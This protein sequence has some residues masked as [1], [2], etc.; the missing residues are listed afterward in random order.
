[1]SKGT[2]TESPWITTARRKPE[3]VKTLGSTDKMWQ[4][5]D[6]V[7]GYYPHNMHHHDDVR[8]LNKRILRFEKTYNPYS[9]K[10][11]CPVSREHVM[12]P[13][14]WMEIPVIWDK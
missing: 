1:M 14:K 4:H 12:P 6:I 8:F 5:S 9:T 3:M 7:I 10:W 13:T 11:Y 2:L